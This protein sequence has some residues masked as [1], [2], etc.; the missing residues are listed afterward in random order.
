MSQFSF[1]DP[2]YTWIS[3]I[4][5]PKQVYVV[6]PFSTNFLWD[7]HAWD[8]GAQCQPRGQWLLPMRVTAHDDKMLSRR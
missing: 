3:K 7:P 2:S 6:I 8:G 5:A 4:L 1:E